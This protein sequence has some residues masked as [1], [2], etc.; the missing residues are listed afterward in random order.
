MESLIMRSIKFLI[1]CS[2]LSILLGGCGDKEQERQGDAKAALHNMFLACKAYWADNGNALCT[3]DQISQVEYG[4]V[5]TE[6]IEVTISNGQ[7]STFNA[8]ATF[9]TEETNLGSQDL[10]LRGGFYQMDP[11][12]VIQTLNCLTILG[13]LDKY[14][15]D[16]IT[17]WCS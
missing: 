4:Y 7:E 8:F 14:P 5:A 15:E 1:I 3:V 6:G 9:R 13:H 11:D 2:L 12:G 10:V 17:A 16:T